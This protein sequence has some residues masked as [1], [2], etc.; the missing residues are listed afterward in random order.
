M[1]DFDEVGAVSWMAERKQIEKGAI[2]SVNTISLATGTND[3]FRDPTPL[4]VADY[5]CQPI[6]I[7]RRDSGFL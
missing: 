4:L 5:S 1:L 6:I 7:V 3:S 2:P